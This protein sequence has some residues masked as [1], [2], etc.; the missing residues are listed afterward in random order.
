MAIGAVSSVQASPELIAKNAAIAAKAAAETAKAIEES[1]VTNT[2]T[3]ADELEAIND[4]VAQMIEQTRLNN[5][6]KVASYEKE[7]NDV[8]VDNNMTARDIGVLKK[9][10]SRLNL[11]SALEK[12]D[13]V[14]VFKFRVTTTAF[15]KMGTLIAD[16]E[17]KDKVRIQIFSKSS[18]V[19]IA[20]KDPDSGE[21]FENYQ[22][23]EAGTLELKQGDYAVRVSR[24][25]GDSLSQNDIQYVLQLNQGV[26]KNDFD[27]I[28][29]GKSSSTDQY[30]FAATLG[31]E[32]E[33]LMDA[34]SAGSSFIS[35]LPAIGTSATD[36]L[37]GALYDALF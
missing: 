9:N 25:P 18:G 6:G 14:D 26:Y 11:F 33:G 15:T 2:S 27:T 10:D 31:A 12:G 23:L 21:A 28:E 36:K 34:L 1:N 30:G 24:M 22:K 3:A 37:T 16:P 29:K 13:A 5:A 7:T 17:D 4:Q 20:D 35:S 32:T 8:T 19:L